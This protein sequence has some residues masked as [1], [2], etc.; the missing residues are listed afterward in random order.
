MAVAPFKP[1]DSHRPRRPMAGVPRPG[2]EGYL[3][4][5][6]ASPRVIPCAFLGQIVLPCSG[7]GEAPW[8]GRS[9]EL[10]YRSSLYITKQDEEMAS[11]K[12]LTASLTIF[13]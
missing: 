2:L 10:S 1:A 12:V 4:V 6:S 5:A 13:F 8:C 7:G 9:T 11:L 3:P